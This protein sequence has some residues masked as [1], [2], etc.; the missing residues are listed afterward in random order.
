MHLEIVRY[1]K[2]AAKSDEL[3]SEGSKLSSTQDPK[4]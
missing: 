3:A 4:V 1:Q 2:D